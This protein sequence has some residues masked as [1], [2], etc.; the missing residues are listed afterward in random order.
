MSRGVRGSGLVGGATFPSPPLT[1]C[2]AT[3]VPHADR[4]HA[5]RL[6]A[7][8]GVAIVD[9]FAP[10]EDTLGRIR[11]ASVVYSS[12]QHGIIA[13]EFL[14]GRDASE[15]LY[16]DLHALGAAFTTMMDDVCARPTSGV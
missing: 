14:S 8:T 7:R 11:A 10:V 13:A 5:R 6:L 2:G 3:V 16:P 4:K 1:E 15:I 9:V 12:S